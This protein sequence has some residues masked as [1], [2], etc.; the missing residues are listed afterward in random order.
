[1][2]ECFQSGKTSCFSCIEWKIRDNQK[3][4]LN[5][6]TLAQLYLGNLVKEIST[7]KWLLSNIEFL[8]PKKLSYLQQN[9][10]FK[11]GLSCSRF[12]IKHSVCLHFDVLS[13]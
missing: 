13:S 1:M 5:L 3:Q 4:F 9:D 7:I 2:S 6:D 10:T 8:C 12:K 11:T